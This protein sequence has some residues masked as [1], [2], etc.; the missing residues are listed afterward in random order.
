MEFFELLGL[1]TKASK[2]QPPKLTHVLQ[3][4]SFALSPQGVTVAPAERR[5][6][7]LTEEI[8]GALATDFLSPEEAH[9]LAGR[10][11]DKVFFA[12]GTIPVSFLK[13]FAARRAFIYVLEIVAQLIVLSTFARHLPEFWV[14]WIDNSA[15]E[16]ALRKGYGKDMAVNGMLAA[17]WALVSRMQWSPEF[18]RV[19]SATNIADAVSLGDLSTATAQGWTQVRPPVKNILA[20]FAKCANDLDYTNNGATE[21]LLNTTN[22]SFETTLSGA[23]VRRAGCRM[24]PL[25]VASSSFGAKIRPSR[26]SR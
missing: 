14:A 11:G 9:R 26:V 12:Y 19:K 8:Q 21:D 4:A 1:R 15:G 13:H 5:V 7:R 23:G 22:S 16:A 20:V 17:F 6:N 3:G 18:N 25:D 2:A 24:R 10:I